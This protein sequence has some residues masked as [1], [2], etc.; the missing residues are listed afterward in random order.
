MPEPPDLHPEPEPDHLDDT[1]D[2]YFD[3]VP[4]PVVH[5]HRATLGGWAGQV[6]HCRRGLLIAWLSKLVEHDVSPPLDTQAELRGAGCGGLSL[7]LSGWHGAL[8]LHP[9][10]VTIAQLTVSE[11]EVAAGGARRPELCLALEIRRPLG[12]PRAWTSRARLPPRLRRLIATRA[13]LSR[14]MD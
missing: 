8:T 12:A 10:D 14:S 9:A 13:S 4:P 2:L 11:A 3:A 6:S 5:C 7:Q 1:L